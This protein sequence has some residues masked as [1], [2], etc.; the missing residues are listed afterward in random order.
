MPGS[1]GG[2]EGLQRIGSEAH[3]DIVPATHHVALGEKILGHGH[4]ILFHHARLAGRGDRMDGVAGLGPHFQHLVL[5]EGRPD[6][7]QF[8]LL[9]E[10]FGHAWSPVRIS[11]RRDGFEG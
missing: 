5:K 1:D 8:A 9:F 10:D 6:G 4:S 11:R 3:I 2:A 7:F